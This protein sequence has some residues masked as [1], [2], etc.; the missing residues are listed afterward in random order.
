MPERVAKN[1][2]RDRAIEAGERFKQIWSVTRRVDGW[3]LGQEVE[4]GTLVLLKGLTAREL[5][6]YLKGVLDGTATGRKKARRHR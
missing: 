5:D 1:Y 2:L 6:A 4:S 3:S